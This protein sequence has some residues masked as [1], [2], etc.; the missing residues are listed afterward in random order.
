MHTMSFTH[1]TAGCA[2]ADSRPTTPLIGR[3][4]RQAR[5]EQMAAPLIQ[6]LT[7]RAAMPRANSGLPDK[8]DEQDTASQAVFTHLPTVPASASLPE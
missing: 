1:E 8:A 4:G 6:A 7:L 5:R 2:L 3:T